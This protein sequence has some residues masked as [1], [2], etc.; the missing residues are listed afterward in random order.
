[1]KSGHNASFSK[2]K[3]SIQPKPCQR[4]R[5]FGKGFSRAPAC[6]PASTVKDDVRGFVESRNDSI[7]T[8]SSGRHTIELPPVVMNSRRVESLYRLFFFGG[9]AEGD[10]RKGHNVLRQVQQLPKLL[11]AF[12]GGIDAAP[13]RAQPF[14]M[15]RKQQGLCGCGAVKHPVAFIFFEGDV[16]A[17][18]NG[19]GCVLEHGGIRMK[20]RDLVEKRKPLVWKY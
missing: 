13:D 6:R 18:E 19:R 20:L 1:M 15:C 11:H 12:F 3:D 10:E 9:K 17:D 16:A 7:F 14:R 5:L 2:N 8:M 4:E